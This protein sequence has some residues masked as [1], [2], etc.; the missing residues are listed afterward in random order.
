M[1][2]FTLFQISAQVLPLDPDRET[3]H[4]QG[5]RPGD[6]LP[7]RHAGQGRPPRAAPDG[8]ARGGGRSRRIPRTGTSAT[9]FTAAQF[10]KSLNEPFRTENHLLI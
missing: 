10:F 7:P 3:A 2:A 1:H 4:D 9:R 8:L 6:P 5:L